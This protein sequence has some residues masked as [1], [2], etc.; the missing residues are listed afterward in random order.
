MLYSTRFKIYVIEK[1]PRG[2]FLIL[3]G[4]S[5][6]YLDSSVWCYQ[7]QEQGFGI[8]GNLATNG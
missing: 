2:N 3:F 6:N 5:E 7:A 1:K 4:E 8:L